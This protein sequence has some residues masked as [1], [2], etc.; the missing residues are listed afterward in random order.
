MYRN[1]PEGLHT[2]EITKAQREDLLRTHNKLRQ[3]Q[4][5][6]DDCRDISVSHLR[7][8]DDAICL[9]HRIGKFCPEMDEDGNSRWYADWVFIENSEDDD[10]D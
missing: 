1:K 8:L 9:I 10:D 3:M 7:D 2:M 6:I 5:Y 4:N